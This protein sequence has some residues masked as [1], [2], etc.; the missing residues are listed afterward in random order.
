MCGIF[1]FISLNYGNNNATLPTTYCNLIS[2][3]KSTI[4]TRG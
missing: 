4:K 3:A 1:C 2:E